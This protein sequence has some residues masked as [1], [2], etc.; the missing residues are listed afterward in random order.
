[1]ALVAHVHFRL[2]FDPFEGASVAE[3]LLTNVTVGKSMLLADDLG[4]IVAFCLVEQLRVRR[5]QFIHFCQSVAFVANAL[6]TLWR[7]PLNSHGNRSF[8]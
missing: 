6:A 1:M 4:A 3:I 8:L 7:L 5:R 2:L